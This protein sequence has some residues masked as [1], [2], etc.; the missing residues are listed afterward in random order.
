MLE[1][2]TW[3]AWIGT[4]SQLALL[5]VV[6]GSIILGYIKVLPNILKLRKEEREGR[7]QADADERE[8]IASY[9]RERLTGCEQRIKELTEL[10]EALQQKIAGDAMQRVQSEISLVNVLIQVVDAPQLRQVLDALESRK[11]SL[12][13]Q[14]LLEIANDKGADDEIQRA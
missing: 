13:G 2:I 12:A 6:S 1:G 3:P 4:P 8:N 7:R 5:V 11:I 9:Y 14:Q 10:V